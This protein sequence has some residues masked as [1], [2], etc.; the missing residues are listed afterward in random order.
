MTLKEIYFASRH[1]N[2]A[3]LLAIYLT[4]LVMY[5][6]YRLPRRGAAV[7]LAGMRSILYTEPSLATS[8]SEV[9]DDIRKLLTIYNLDPITRCYVCCPSCYYLYEYSAKAKKRKAPTSSDAHDNF[10]ENPKIN[11]ADSPQ[12]VTSVPTECTHRRVHASPACG[13]S[14]FDSVVVNNKIYVIPRFKYVAQNL[15]QWVGRL[16]SRPTIEDQVYKAFRRPQKEY[17]EDMWDAGHLCRI[18]LKPGE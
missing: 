2:N 10:V 11:M 8:A 9:P 18:L 16:L 4:T 1:P 7:L 17:M 15:K 6:L 14:L 13:E 3:T 12:L 5:V